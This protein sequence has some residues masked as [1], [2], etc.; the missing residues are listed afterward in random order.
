MNGNPFSR[1]FIAEVMGVMSL[2]SVLGMSTVAC[3]RETQGSGV[4]EELRIDGETMAAI[5]VAA[6]T[7]VY[8]GHQSVGGNILQGL[9]VLLSESQTSW[10]ISEVGRSPLPSGPALL[11][12]KIGH[13]GVP[14][15]KMDD[16]AKSVRGLA[17]PKPKLAFMKLCFVDVNRK[18]DVNKLIAYYAK[19]LR[20]LKSDFPG[21]VFGHATV[22]LAPAADS[23]KDR[24]KRLAG[25]EIA[26]DQDNLRRAEYNALLRKEFPQDPLFDLDVIESTHRDGARVQ[27]QLNG[28]VGYALASEYAGDGDGHLNATGSKLTA[29]E[30]IRFIASAAV[31]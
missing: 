20:Q 8:W 13:N 6:G 15:E 11:H 23:L 26:R 16:F 27:F 31:R 30:L 14:T 3:H 4:A 19:T 22:P 21:M 12:Q 18:T 24:L 25:I 10:A 9:A 5:K 2:C 17:D 28:Q 7:R 1:W 29:M